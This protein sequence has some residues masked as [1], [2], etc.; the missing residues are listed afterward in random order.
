MAKFYGEV[1][2]A[3]TTETTDGVWTEVITEKKYSGD[4]LRSTRRLQ[5]GENLNDNIT[6]NN[7]ISIVADPF[8]VQNF[9]NIRYAKWNGVLWK[10]TDVEVQRP[11]LILTLGGVYNGEQIQSTDVT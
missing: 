5:A 7:L 6:V 10:V 1:G 4:V 9:Q 3:E 8:A 11:R 2:Y